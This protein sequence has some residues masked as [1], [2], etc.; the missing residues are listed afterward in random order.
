MITGDENNSL[1]STGSFKILSSFAYLDSISK[2]SP[3][4][5]GVELHD[6]KG[7]AARAKPPVKVEEINLRRLVFM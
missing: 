1:F 3:G 4:A 5:V 6:D 7:V 2:E